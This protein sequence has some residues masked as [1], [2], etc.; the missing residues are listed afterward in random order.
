MAIAKKCDICGRLYEPYD[1]KGINGI[2]YLYIDGMGNWALKRKFD[3]CP[4]CLSSINNHIESLKGE[5]NE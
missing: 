1:N 3:C 4:L 5:K 2:G